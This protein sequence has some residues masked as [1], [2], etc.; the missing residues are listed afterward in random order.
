M[1]LLVVLILELHAGGADEEGHPGGARPRVRL[2]PLHQSDDSTAAAAGRLW[3]L[4]RRRRPNDG[5]QPAGGGSQRHGRRRN[6]GPLW[7]RPA[8]AATTG[9]PRP[10]AA[11]S[12]GPPDRAAAATAGTSGIKSEPLPCFNRKQNELLS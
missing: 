5:C 2:H 7:R 12:A 8:G 1:K 4:R 6:D 10:P 3:P 11:G 9:W